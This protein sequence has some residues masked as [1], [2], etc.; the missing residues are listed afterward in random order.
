[1]IY[2]TIIFFAHCT[3]LFVFLRCWQHYTSLT[4]CTG[5][6]KTE[7]KDQQGQVTTDRHPHLEGG[8]SSL[9][10]DASSSS[11]S[12]LSTVP[13]TLEACPASNNTNNNF[14]PQQQQGELPPLSTVLDP[15]VPL[16]GEHLRMYLVLQRGG[17]Q[18]QENYPTTNLGRAWNFVYALRDL[19]TNFNQT[20]QRNSYA[21]MAPVVGNFLGGPQY[22]T[23]LKRFYLQY[24]PPKQIV[25]SDILKLYK[26]RR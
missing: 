5:E 15:W 2:D 14:G 6:A 16:T 9:M 7:C 26:V 17:E 23:M 25:M 3:A 22:K 11:S 21:V 20:Y 4:S 19:V 24:D 10:M 18:Q 13:S 1:M 12:S 8:Q